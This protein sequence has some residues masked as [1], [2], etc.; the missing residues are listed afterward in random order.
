MSSR[1]FQNIREKRGLA[2]AVSSSLTAYHDV[3]SLTVYAGCDGAAVSQVIDL[4]VEEFRTL[5][6]RPMPDEE[7]QRAKDHLKGSLVLGL[8]S[9]TSRMSQLA[10]SEMYFGRQI[11][12]SETLDAI[13]RV[14]CDDVLRVAADLF[15]A[16]A[17]AGTV[18]GPLNGIDLAPSKLDLG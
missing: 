3:G 15:Q 7:L 18:V 6:Q 13:E 9:T 2:Y 1:L 12:L 4:V 16:G 8:E 10:R 17:L 14:T 5:K 11:A